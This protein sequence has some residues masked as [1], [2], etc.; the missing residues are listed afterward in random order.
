MKLRLLSPA[1]LC[2]SGIAL[3]C[4]GGGFEGSYNLRSSSYGFTGSAMLAP[5]N[6][7]RVNLM[8]LLADRQGIG[9]A[10]LAYPD[11]SY[12]YN[13][14][15]RVFLDWRMLRAALTR[16]APV[17]YSADTPPYEGTRCAGF[18]AG[19][20]AL[21][22]AMAA[23]AGLPSGERTALAKARAEGEAVCK[24]ATAWE[25]RFSIGSQ[26]G[27]PIATTAQWPT[28]ASP[29]GREFLAYEQAAEAFYAE[30]FEAARTGFAALIRAGDPFV[31]ETAA[32]MVARAEFAAAQ[33]PAFTDYG[34]YDDAKV[35]RAAAARGNAALA[36]YLQ[37]WPNGRYAASAR[38][39]Q[40]RGTW[41]AGD[42]P[43][44]AGTYAGMIDGAG[45][46][47]GKVADLVEEIDT[48]LPYTTDS[49]VAGR[50]VLLLAM[51]DLIAL[52]DANAGDN[53]A[54]GD[55]PKP[56]L[57]A[58]AL[59]AQAP[60]FAGHEDLFGYLQATHAYYY[61]RDYRRV[62]QLLPDDARRPSYSNLAFSRQMLRGMALAALHDRN[63]AGFWQELI[64]GAKGLW[65]RPLVELALAMNWERAGKLDSVFAP[66]SPITEPVLRTIL[67]DHSAGAPLLRRI[68]QQPAL[69]AGERDHA[70]Y[71]LLENEL[72][73]GQ[74]A[75]FVS[76]T[77][78]PLSGEKPGAAIF[79]RGK[80]GDGSYACAPLTTS[81]RALIANPGDAPALLCLG[82]FFR[83]HGIGHMG[84]VADPPKSDELGGYARG[85]AGR[86]LGR[87]EFYDKVIA[88]PSARPDDRA[89]AL[90][91]A[92]ICYAPSGSSECGPEVPKSQRKAWFDQLRSQYP[93]SPWTK[94]LKYY[95]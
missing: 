32:Y 72:G 50:H 74:F 63:E 48:K 75:A 20:A 12:D 51:N 22:A 91:R 70:L 18:A 88:S 80:F 92:V 52:R 43:A 56:G 55:P 53:G 86:L 34:S 46:D 44:L 76:D 47:P 45:R 68:V 77:V 23:N 37:A 10:G 30:R 15:G 39:L 17:D 49:A 27:K 8:F 42:R 57:S 21:D 89:Y 64:G 71:T 38:A 61:A 25:R 26:Q 81:V 66:G 2:A 24:D 41:L 84:Y 65:Q 28:V 4:A 83:L 11:S 79:T 6:D 67:I 5:G 16:A 85:F 58:A 69:D 29:A 36:A 3:A 14:N 87:A 62:L 93:N 9:T 19:T 35:D 1:V 90:Y 13:D 59:D 7:S 73:R 54:P 60:L 33:A 78:L 94:K 95:W 40:R 82:E 31:R